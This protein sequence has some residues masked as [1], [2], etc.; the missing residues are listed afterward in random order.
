MKTMITLA[1]TI[2]IA[3]SRGAAIADDVPTGTLEQLGQ[4]NK[5]HKTQAGTFV[6]ADPFRLTDANGLVQAGPNTGRH[7]PVRVKIEARKSL[8][9]ISPLILAPRRWTLRGQRFWASRR[10]AG[11]G[12]ARRA[13]TGKHRPTTPDRTGFS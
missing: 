4:M 9:A 3:F 11:E 10:Y 13:T 5:A 8:H 6:S 12:T 7:Y 1:L 2:F